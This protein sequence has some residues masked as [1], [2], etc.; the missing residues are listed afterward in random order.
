MHMLFEDCME[1]TMEK[2]I[3]TSNQNVVFGKVAAEKISHEKSL[4]TFS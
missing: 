2:A 4:L 3:R 1:I